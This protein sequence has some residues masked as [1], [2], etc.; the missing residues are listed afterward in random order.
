MSE[1]KQRLYE[2]EVSPPKEVWDGLASA[3]D[4]INADVPLSQKLQAVETP[5]LP[6]TWEKIQSALDTTPIQK[7]KSIVVPLRKM[8]YAA[9]FLGLIFLSYLLF[10]NK[11][12]EATDGI[13][14]SETNLKTEDNLPENNSTAKSDTENN[15]NPETGDPGIRVK[16]EPAFTNISTIS[17]LPASKRSRTKAPVLLSSSGKEIA[18]TEELKE[19]IFKEQIDDLSMIASNDRYMVMVN[20][21]GRMVKLPVRFSNLAPYL[22]DKSTEQDYLDILFEESTYW[23]EKFR[24]WRQKLAQ[25]SVSPSVDN[26]FD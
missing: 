7:N 4:E 3:L 19:K 16:Q 2:M 15:S 17:G 24:E 9:V 5:P 26:F 6:G 23:K 8:A 12:T 11:K 13:V 22:Q 20:A 14:T 10:F 25:S 18:L 1:L 21:D